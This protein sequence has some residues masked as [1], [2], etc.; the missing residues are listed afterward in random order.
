MKGLTEAQR[1]I[2]DFISRFILEHSYSPSYNEIKEHFNFASLNAVAKHICAL[3]RKGLI[4][5]EANCS[6]SISLVA[7]ANLPSA[8]VKF[9]LVASISAGL[10][11]FFFEEPEDVF[12]SAFD[13]DP[14]ACVTVQVKGDGFHDELLADG[15]Y[16]IVKKGSMASEGDRTITIVNEQA[17]FVMQ[18]YPLEDPYVKFIS[19]NKQFSPM[20]LQKESIFIYG[21]VVGVWRVLK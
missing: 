1:G 21:V 6:R 19:C 13:L 7:K 17:V 18:Y 9:P 10:P 8:G 4:D 14:S 15:D 11:M 5:K 3:K 2:F 12:L 20:I 16:L